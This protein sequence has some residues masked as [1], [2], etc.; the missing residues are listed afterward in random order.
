M[1]RPF[2]GTF[3]GWALARPHE[4]LMLGI[5]L[6]MPACYVTRAWTTLD[7]FYVEDRFLGFINWVPIE[8]PS[9]L[10]MQGVGQPG[11]PAKDL[12][13]QKRPSRPLS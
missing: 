9:G 2:S 6:R 3:C 5:P 7:D 13:C 4:T 12:T 10:L 8:L 11:V 1:G